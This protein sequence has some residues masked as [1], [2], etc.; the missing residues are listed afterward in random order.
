M[1]GFLEK[2]APTFEPNLTRGEVKLK[3]DIYP[4]EVRGDLFG[5]IDVNSLGQHIASYILGGLPAVIITDQIVKEMQ[6]TLDEAMR[7]VDLNKFIAFLQSGIQSYREFGELIKLIFGGLGEHVYMEFLDVDQTKFVCDPDC[8]IQFSEVKFVPK[9][10][11]DWIYAFRQCEIRIIQ[12]FS[13]STV[14]HTVGRG[15]SLWKLADK[16]YCSGEMFLYL[17]YQNPHLAKSG[18][19]KVGQTII[20][21]PSFEFLKLKKILYTKAKVCG[22]AGLVPIDRP[23]G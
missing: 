18:K 22:R 11:G 15:D 5:F 2:T 6:K 20:I 19:L 14:I 13:E 17:L 23:L 1:R 3:P 4:T 16:F 21:P 7:D 12:S 10:Y 9:D 8:N